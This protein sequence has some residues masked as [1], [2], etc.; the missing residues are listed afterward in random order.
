MLQSLAGKILSW[1]E[2]EKLLIRNVLSL[3]SQ[4]LFPQ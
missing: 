4:L 3:F 2:D 1:E